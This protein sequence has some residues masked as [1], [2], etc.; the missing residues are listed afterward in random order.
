MPPIT[1]KESLSM[2]TIFDYLLCT[3]ECA[4]S[5]VLAG[6][7]LSLPAVSCV[8]A[9]VAGGIVAIIAGVLLCAVVLAFTLI[10]YAAVVAV[11]D[12]VHYLY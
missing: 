2:D 11:R 1:N 10:A 6:C 5:I 7:V 3:A 12:R 9:I 8:Q 4:L